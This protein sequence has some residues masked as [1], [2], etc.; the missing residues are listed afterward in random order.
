[1]LNSVVNLIDMKFVQNA[2]HKWCQHNR[3]DPNKRQAGK[4]SITTGK[5]FAESVFSSLTGP[6]PPKIID[7]SEL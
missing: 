6:I 1:M 2:M 4:E 5:D 7:A 3:S